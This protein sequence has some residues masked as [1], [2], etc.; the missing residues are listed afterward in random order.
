MD[1]RKVVFRET[2]IIAIGELICTGIMLGL[3][4][5]LKVWNAGVWL[6]AAIGSLVAVANFFFM[7]IS[8]SLAADRAAEGNVKG[9]Q[10]LLSASFFL[11]YGVMF[12]VLFV[13]AKSGYCNVIALVVPLVF[14]RPVLTVGE[15]FRKK[16]DAPNG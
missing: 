12:A 1:P 15:F 11:R 13:A 10:G 16:G 9:G 4:A 8:T 6:G 7:A 2:A 14:V 3:F 5:L